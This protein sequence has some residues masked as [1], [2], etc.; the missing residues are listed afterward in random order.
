MRAWF[1]EAIAE[2]TAAGESAL[3]IRAPADRLLALDRRLRHR[4]LNEDPA[5]PVQRAR[6]GDLGCDRRSTWASER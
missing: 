4:A 5:M 6:E 2:G 3:P 1:A